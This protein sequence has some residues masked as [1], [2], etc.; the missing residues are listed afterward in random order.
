MYPHN[1]LVICSAPTPKFQ[2]RLIVFCQWAFYPMLAREQ[3]MYYVDVVNMINICALYSTLSLANC[4]IVSTVISQH[5]RLFS[6]HL[7]I[8]GQPSNSTPLTTI[9]SV[10]LYA[11]HPFYTSPIHSLVHSDRKFTCQRTHT[12]SFLTQHNCHSNRSYQTLNSQHINS[13]SFKKSHIQRFF[14][15]ATVA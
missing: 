15:I 11:A 7:S 10:L 1:V 2:T 6:P 5:S 4:H 13:S 14:L 12:T 3:R 8:S 9:S